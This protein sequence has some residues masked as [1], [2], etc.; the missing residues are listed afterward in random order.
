MY[1][2]RAVIYQKYKS[3]WPLLH[4]ITAPSR[5]SSFHHHHRCFVV[6]LQ[7]NS[8]ILP[9]R[10]RTR[11][12][13]LW[14]YR[15]FQSLSIWFLR[16]CRLRLGWMFVLPV[17]CILRRQDRIV[18]QTFCLFTAAAAMISSLIV[19]AISIFM[20][21]ANPIPAWSS[22]VYGWCLLVLPSLNRPYR[23]GARTA[24]PDCVVLVAGCCLSSLLIDS[25]SSSSSFSSTVAN[26]DAG[27]DV[28]A[29]AGGSSII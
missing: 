25:S 8:M 29:G 24:R 28:G 9:S 27:A 17:C 11:Q 6:L 10:I 1:Q 12:Q 16:F 14:L 5:C 22:S 4:S 2:F 26:A 18:H 3:L 13:S 21:N 23:S 19:V 20:M 7:S 15:R